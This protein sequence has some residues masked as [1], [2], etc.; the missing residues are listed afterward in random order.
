MPSYTI[1][2]MHPTLFQS[3]YLKQLYKKNQT[4]IYLNAL[5]RNNNKAIVNWILGNGSNTK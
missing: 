4:Y 5:K 3:Q 2:Q 1:L